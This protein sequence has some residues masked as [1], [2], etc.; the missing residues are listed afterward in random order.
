MS[1]KRRSHEDNEVSTDAEGTG[2]L[3]K[4]E[5]DQTSEG[6]LS[7][8]YIYREREREIDGVLHICIFFLISQSLSQV[9]LNCG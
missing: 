7:N 6:F 1:S 8:I 2:L 5:N 4:L 3:L 9:E